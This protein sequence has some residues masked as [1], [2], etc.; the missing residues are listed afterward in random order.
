[1]FA[2]H[3]KR[4]SAGEAHLHSGVSAH[5]S[6]QLSAGSP[7]INGMLSLFLQPRLVS[8]G[9]YPSQSANS[10]CCPSKMTLALTVQTLQL[11]GQL[12]FIHTGFFSQSPFCAHRGHCVL[13]LSLHG[14]DCFV[15][16][17][18][19]TPQLKRQLDFI[20]SLFPSQSPLAFHSGHCCASL[21]TQGTSG[22]AG[23][24]AVGAAG[25]AAVG[26]LS[27][28]EQLLQQFDCIHSRLLVQ[29]PL[30]FHSGHCCA[31]LST[32]GTSGAAGAAGAAAVGVLSVAEQLLQQF[33][34]IHSR[35]LVQSPL[36]FHSGHCCASLSTHGVPGAAG[37]AGTAGAAGAAGATGAEDIGALPVAEQLLQQF[38]CIHSRL[39]VQSPLAFHSGH[40]CASLS[41]HAETVTWEAVA[42]VA[43]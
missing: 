30:A 43:A 10:G 6:L 32:H 35:L 38:D 15:G 14:V 34:C 9:R 23:A 8:A 31:S 22:A 19:Q 40:C 5:K 33:D 7:A 17:G 20:H 36:A 37:A 25:A 11:R 4:V 12:S 21:S 27:V 39:L 16:A 3:S 18:K 2:K 24:A 13:S 41:T 28:A 26:V 29:S 42:W 1:V